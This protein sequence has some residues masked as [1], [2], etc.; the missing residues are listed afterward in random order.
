MDEKT[1]WNREALRPKRHFCFLYQK[2]EE[3]KEFMERLASTAKER[4]WRILHLFRPQ[5]LHRQPP[6]NT[7]IEARSLQDFH[8][9]QEN[10]SP[11][12]AAE[13]IIQEKD[14]ILAKGGRALCLVV[15]I[16][17]CKDGEGLILQFE[18]QLNR[19]CSEK[20]LVICQ[21]QRPCL[22]SSLI[23]QLLLFHQHLII[24][25][26]LFHNDKPLEQEV[27]KEDLYQRLNTHLI[28]N[29]K[30]LQ[31]VEQNLQWSRDLCLALFEEFPNPLFLSDAR[32][33]FID[34]N[35]SWLTFTGK[36]LEEEK[37]NGWLKGLKEG[38]KESFQ[39]VFQENLKKRREFEIEIEI[40]HHSGQY[41]YLL[42]A[43]RP[44]SNLSGHF[45]GFLFSCFDI[46][47]RRKKEERRMK[48]LEEEL[49]NLRH[50]SNDKK[51][52]ITAGLF[53][54]T[55]IKEGLP[56][57]FEELSEDYQH[58]M[59]ETVLENL[60]GE[61]KSLEEKKR[62]F[63]NRLG[64]FQASP[65]DLI[66]IHSWVLE[67]FV[68]ETVEERFLLYVNEGRILLVEIMGYLVSYYRKYCSGLEQT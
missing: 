39:R 31:K 48:E 25:H 5:Q 38:D 8:L 29:M 24:D 18:E 66:D 59:E 64:F 10:F 58:L 37:E 45:S 51:T 4:D 55:S 20:T 50:I 26:Q 9:S 34:F 30:H 15:Q 43:A 53:G 54:L 40:L 41:R 23:S 19:I 11:P 21:Y 17:Y 2:K 63:V 12:K 57:T 49:E 60:Y 56:D 1:L 14:K 27:Q 44:V 3:Q 47:Q 68:E 33:T 46:T 6:E 36:T 13:K 16:D 22:S 62:A 67:R 65:K 32:G 35:H 28:W 61:K 42:C 52:K 7:F